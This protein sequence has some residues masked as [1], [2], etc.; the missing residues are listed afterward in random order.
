MVYARQVR[1]RG[2]H[3]AGLDPGHKLVRG[4]ARRS[5][6]AV[7]DRDELRLERLELGDGLV[8]LLRALRRL[9]REELEREGRRVGVKEVADVHWNGVGGR[10]SLDFGSRVRLGLATFYPLIRID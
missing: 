6:G 8:Q 1:G 10:I 5:A 7:R 2:E 4:I 3:A 9:G